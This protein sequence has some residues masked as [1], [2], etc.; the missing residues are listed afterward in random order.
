MVSYDDIDRTVQQP[1]DAGFHITAGAQRRVHFPVG[2]HSRNILF[3]EQQMMRAYLSSYFNADLLRL[4]DQPYRLL[5]ADMTY[6]VMYTGSFSEQNVAP[7]V[8]G[9]RLVRNPL[10]AMLGR[11]S[12]FVNRTAFDQ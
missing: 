9:F 6:M 12:S 11:K 4:A 3:R 5:C 7:Y 8:N 10:Q 1:L 2:V